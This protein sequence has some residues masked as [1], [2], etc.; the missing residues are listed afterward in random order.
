MHSCDLIS[1]SHLGCCAKTMKLTKPTLP[2][3]SG[4]LR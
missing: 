4:L 2:M 1:G 3:S